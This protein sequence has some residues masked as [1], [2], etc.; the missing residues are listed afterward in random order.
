M[1]CFASSGASVA[2]TRRTRASLV[3]LAIRRAASRGIQAA[4]IR[5]MLVSSRIPSV[6]S[7]AQ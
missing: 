3:S 1:G 4:L 5:A 7:E 6:E 2:W